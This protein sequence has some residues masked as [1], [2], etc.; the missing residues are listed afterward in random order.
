VKNHGITFLTIED[1]LS[2]HSLA[3]AASGGLDGIR[4]MVALGAAIAKP[5]NFL[6]YEKCYDIF[7]LSAIMGC[8]IIQNHPFND[9]NK[10]AGLLASYVMLRI[11][12]IYC[13]VDAVNVDACHEIIIAIAA[14]KKSEMELAFFLEKCSSN[15]SRT[16]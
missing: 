12:R 2:L 7:H 16:D 8:A 5:Q 6:I 15:P 1:V 14:G 3:I 9:G 11:N 4:D 10:R 13:P